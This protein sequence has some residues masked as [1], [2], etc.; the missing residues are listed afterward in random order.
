[1]QAVSLGVML[2]HSALVLKVK[3]S[4]NAESAGTLRA[5]LMGAGPVEACGELLLSAR[6]C[7]GHLLLL[8]S[9][10]VEGSHQGAPPC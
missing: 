5:L 8:V 2:R 6:S 9:A 10:V 1:M 7:L 4:Q 3:A